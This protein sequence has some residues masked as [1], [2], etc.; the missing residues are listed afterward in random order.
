LQAANE[1][2]TLERKMNDVDMAIEKER[3]SLSTLR[4]STAGLE[5]EWKT[6][7]L[8]LERAEERHKQWL[9]KNPD[10]GDLP[11]LKV[12]ITTE[13]SAISKL[14]SQVRGLSTEADQIKTD[15]DSLNQ[16]IM[17]LRARLK[18]VSSTFALRMA[19]LKNI[20][21]I[22]EPRIC[23][24]AAA[25]LD[26]QRSQGRLHGEVIGPIVAHIELTNPDDAVLAQQLEHVLSL[27][28]KFGY[29][30]TDARDL[31]MVTDFRVNTDRL[32]YVGLWRTATAQSEVDGFTKRL[33]G[34]SW[35]AFQAAVGASCT[36][37]SDA[38][39][40]RPE[41]RAVLYDQARLLDS[42]CTSKPGA[43]NAFIK[44]GL[45]LP[46]GMQLNAKEGSIRGTRN[47]YDGSRG[48]QRSGYRNPQPELVHLYAKQQDLSG[49]RAAL[50]ER[51]AQLEA[52]S[53]KLGLLEQETRALNA[54]MGV[55][56][57]RKRDLSELQLEHTRQ[58][59]SIRALFREAE[60]A[61]NALKD[62]ASRVRSIE[63]CLQRVRDMQLKLM[64]LL[65]TIPERI[66]ALRLA[67]ER[68]W[69]AEVA[70]AAA[71]VRVATAGEDLRAAQGEKE[72][73]R[74]E[75][76]A[77]QARVKASETELHAAQRQLAV[78]VGVV[79][80]KYAEHYASFA[81]L[82]DVTEELNARIAIMDVR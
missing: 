5:E 37:M 65:G 32:P 49:E 68:L 35:E 69:V 63:E 17:N 41:V 23:M 58:V 7:K 6:A 18:R 73:A 3:A 30:C 25:W 71:R 10:A 28:I 66:K 8:K 47:S 33:T 40:C 57:E 67:S 74:K 15:R 19:A 78:N 62:N 2:T 43:I 44:S 75:C 11:A 54:K 20:P 42:L 70:L 81:E 21:G 9:A 24:A 34:S 50:A 22:K 79:K 72:K 13:N 77:A 76:A 26:E 1:L 27:A 52:M 39:I 55:H 12:A 46:D 31:K 4:D 80:S 61:G 56:A 51:E 16:V 45:E 29:I 53:R 82:P 38:I 36:Y 64:A 60:Q 48:L 14:T 59:N